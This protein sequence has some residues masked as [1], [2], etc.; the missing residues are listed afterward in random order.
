MIL[1]SASGISS[2]RATLKM[3]QGMFLISA[4]IW[5]GGG[6]NNFRMG[7]WGPNNFCMGCWGIMY[8]NPKEQYY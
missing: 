6:P 4:V 1:R 7:C 2:C 3:T 5:E 8:T